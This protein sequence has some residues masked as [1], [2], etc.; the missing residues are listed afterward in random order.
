MRNISSRKQ[1]M[2]ERIAA[3]QEMDDVSA[4]HIESALESYLDYNR[5]E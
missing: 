1:S 3:L 4:G 5:K 2:P